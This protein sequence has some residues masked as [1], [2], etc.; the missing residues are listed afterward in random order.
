M[1]STPQPQAALP[2]RSNQP[3]ST[4]TPVNISQ[5]CHL[6]PACYV[7][8]THLL[9]IE[10]NVV[11]H[12]RCRLNTDQGPVI[13]QQGSILNERCILGIDKEFNPK[14]ASVSSS[15][16]TIA[17]SPDLPSQDDGINEL[18]I[19]IGPRAYLQS[20]VKVQPPCTIGD[21]VVLE[22]GVTLLPGCSIGAHSKVCA[23]ITLPA[24]TTIPEWTV[25]YG[26]HGQMRRKRQANLAEDSRLD[27]MSRER[28]GVETLLK[29]NATKNLSTAGGSSK[30][31][32]ASIIRSDSQKG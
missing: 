20:T 6:D 13:I 17:Q 15:A 1:T 19:N 23:G 12:P 7:K 4:S 24:R 10:A 14:P 22:A 9:T 5:Q 27:G 31:K 2:L 11:L 16:A 18:Q 28:H 26:L 29:L 8:G 32:R 30:D 25:V 3:P 21:S